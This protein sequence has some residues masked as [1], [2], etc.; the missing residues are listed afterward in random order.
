M[1]LLSSRKNGLFQSTPPARGATRLD[2]LISMYSKVFQST[3]PAR[4]ATRFQRQNL[5]DAWISIHAPREGG[6]GSGGPLRGARTISIHAPREGGDCP[7]YLLSLQIQPFQSTPPA[8][9][10]T[11]KMH[12]FTCGSLANK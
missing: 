1:N 6:D 11:A 9:G 12:S 4:G 3:P 10:A 7:G 5:Y 8:R 2:K